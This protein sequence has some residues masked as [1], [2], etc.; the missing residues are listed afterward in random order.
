MTG[1]EAVLD[2]L[3]RLADAGIGCVIGGGWGIDALIGH[4][5]R[6]HADLDVIIP[7]EQ[8]ADAIDALASVGFEITTD[9]RPIRLAMTHPD[10]REIDLHPV[11]PGPDGSLIQEVFDG[12]LTYPADEITDGTIGGKGVRCISADLQMRFHDGYEPQDKDRAD[13]AALCAAT[14]LDAPAAYS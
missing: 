4:Q 9:W 8:E 5:T 2:L 3:D 1:P 10:G 12:H 7:A 6:D 14:G 11:R 13:I